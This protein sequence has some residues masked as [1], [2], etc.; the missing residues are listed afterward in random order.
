L[1]IEE[2]VNIDQQKYLPFLMG[3][4]EIEG[5]KLM[6]NK[7]VLLKT[8]K[9]EIG[10]IF[11]LKTYHTAMLTIFI[12]PTADVRKLKWEMSCPSAVRCADKSE[13]ISEIPRNKQRKLLF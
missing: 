2:S 3:F 1:P 10:F 12:T 7:D 9:I 8:S 5:R 13:R 6:R 11:E 4:S